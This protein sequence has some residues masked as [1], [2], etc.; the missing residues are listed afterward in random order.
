MVANLALNIKMYLLPYAELLDD[1][2][3]CVLLSGRPVS[4]TSHYL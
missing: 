3:A 2:K 1:V 4:L